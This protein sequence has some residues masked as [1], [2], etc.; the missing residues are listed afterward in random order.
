LLKTNVFNNVSIKRK[1]MSF[2]SN[3]GKFKLD[4]FPNG[5]PT[6]FNTYSTEVFI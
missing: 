1:Q 5:L 6:F 4:N 2:V 3:G